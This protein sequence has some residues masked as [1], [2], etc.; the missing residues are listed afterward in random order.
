M[1]KT[2][3]EILEELMRTAIVEI[4]QD[5]YGVHFFNSYG[6]ELFTVPFAKGAD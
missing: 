5:E 1:D 2:V 3:E 6:D 4:T